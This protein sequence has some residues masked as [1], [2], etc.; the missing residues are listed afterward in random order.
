MLR[1]AIIG[2]GRVGLPL[3]LFLED[4]G[5]QVVGI[6]NNL[7]LLESLKKG[8]MPF[9]ESGC[10]DLLTN[11]KI[12]L[13]EN[14][15]SVREV[16][17]I[18]ITVGTP[19]V[20]HIETDLSAIRDVLKNLVP[21]LK[22]D[23]SIILR[24]TVGPGTT[25]YLK[26]YIELHSN[27]VV[28][29]DI[30]LAFCPERLAENHALDELKRL[31]QIIGSNDEYSK[32]KCTEF[33]KKFRVELLYTSY[34]GAELVKLFNNAS[35]YVHFSIANH[36][37]VIADQFEENIFDIIKMCNYQYPREKIANPGFT[38]GTCLR[39]DFGFINEHSSSPDLL[40]S[41]WKV[42]EY[43]PYHLVKNLKKHTVLNRK[44]IAV[45]GYTFKADTD[46]TRDSLVPKLI[47]YIERELPSKITICDPFL[48]DDKIGEYENMSLEA[49]LDGAQIVF[50]AN[51]HSCF[52]G[53]DVVKK[54]MPGVW[55]V[56]LWNCTGKD[57]LVFKT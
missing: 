8:K 26:N 46:D 28:G 49:S 21:F 4:C 51:N 42:N 27:L 56:D 45:L 30:A 7:E 39:K 37:A 29:K 52:R 43:M 20:P 6:D 44:N 3:S 47:R 55:F 11:S 10:Q 38:A 40:L 25:L 1:A 19:L 23:Q 33:F 9:L 48:Q 18:I 13:S 57:K 17:Y 36:F 35:R 2:L 50:L 12:K 54:A 32:E 14:I 41:A 5:I 16:D 34:N 24:S 53:E 22:K 31:P 15:S